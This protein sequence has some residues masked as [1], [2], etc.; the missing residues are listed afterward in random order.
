MCVKG[1]RRSE[2]ESAR[3]WLFLVLSVVYGV[4]TMSFLPST[5]FLVGI[6]TMWFL[7]SAFLYGVDTM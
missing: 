7:P 4:H 5:F 2:R 1:R 3:S 6:D